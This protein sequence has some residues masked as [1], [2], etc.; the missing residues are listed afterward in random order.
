MKT[1]Q[2]KLLEAFARLRKKWN[3]SENQRRPGKKL[4]IKKNAD[5]IKKPGKDLGPILKNDPEGRKDM[6]RILLSLYKVLKIYGKKAE[7]LEDVVKLFVFCLAEYPTKVVMHAFKIYLKR[8]DEFPTPSDIVKII[9][10][11]GRPDFNTSIYNVLQKR[12]AS[13]AILTYKE[14]EYIKDYERYMITGDLD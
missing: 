9:E 11:K 1:N 12:M 13:G 10:F 2:I 4:P 14:L 3:L 6:G 8:S 5:C 7:S